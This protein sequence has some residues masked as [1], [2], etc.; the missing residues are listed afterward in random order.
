[1]PNW[2]EGTLKIRGT[3]QDIQNFLEN[4][5]LAI[6]T[7]AAI[8]SFL[9]K[10]KEP[11][12][13]E[14]EKDEYEMKLSSPEGLYIKGTRRAFIESAIEWWFEDNHTEILTIDSFKQAWGVD[15]G[16]F[17][18]I[19]KEFNVDIKIYAFERGMEFNQDIEIHKGEIIKDEEIKFK[20]YSWECI[21]PNIGG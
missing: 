18:K 4:G 10:E 15:A 19:S 16:E 14:I 20:D 2:A 21:F 1:M 17:A 11:N 3:R 5:F 7:G 9:G 13:I 12:K 6:D 8:L